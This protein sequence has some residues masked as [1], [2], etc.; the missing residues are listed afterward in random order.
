[1]T[2]GVVS[3]ALATAVRRRS[4]GPSV[5]SPPMAAD[6]DADLAALR[7]EVD[8]LRALVGYPERAYRELR[9]D[10]VAASEAAKAAELAAGELRG[11]LAEVRTALAR[12][13]RVDHQVRRVM[14]LPVYR[15]VS[16]AYRLGAQ[17][18]ERVQ[19]RLR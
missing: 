19:D 10:V 16:R 12:A 5:H 7:S 8:R 15:T 6:V 1:V 18:R 4:M 3:L 13:E 9:E 11:E 17:L 14:S 2:R